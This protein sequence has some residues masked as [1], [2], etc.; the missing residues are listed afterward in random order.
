MSRRRRGL[1]DKRRQRLVEEVAPLMVQGYSERRI[2]KELGL[3]TGAAHNDVTKVRELWAESFD[4]SREQWQG[5]ILATHE[6]M[7]AELSAA[8]QEGKRGRITRIL[9][10]DGSELLRHEPPDPR[11]LSGIL[12]VTKEAATYL[13][14]REGADTVARMEI[15]EG[16]RHALAPMTPDAY[17]AMLATSNGMAG[18]SAVPAVADLEAVDVE[19]VT[20]SVGVIQRT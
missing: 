5:R 15:P 4:N 17:L 10:P 18:M 8:W 11:W 2:A 7:L 16:T 14:I 13:G 12:A 19:M 3:S 1:T 20:P 9:N 6:W